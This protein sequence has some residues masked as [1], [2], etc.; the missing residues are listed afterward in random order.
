MLLVDVNNL[1]TINDSRGH[2]AGDA[3]LARTSEAIRESLRAGDLCARL[4]DEFMIYARDCDSEN[5]VETAE[6]IFAV[7]GKG[8][9]LAGAPFSLTVGIALCEGDGADFARMYR[10]AEEAMRQ[11]RA[12]GR[13]IGVAPPS[14][15]CGPLAS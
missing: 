2:V 5:A 13:R 3:V 15:A 1:T 8:M 10:E 9:P 12:E 7:A 4:G 14:E 11:A 6:T